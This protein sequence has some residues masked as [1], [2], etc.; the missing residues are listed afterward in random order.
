MRAP[1][2]TFSVKTC[3]L[4]V[5]GSL[6]LSFLP[7]L[8]SSSRCL[9]FLKHIIGCCLTARIKCM[10]PS[11]YLLRIRKGLG[12]C[13]EMGKGTASENVHLLSLPWT[14]GPG[15]IEIRCPF[16]ARQ[17]LSPVRTSFPLTQS[18]PGCRQFWRQGDSRSG[19][20][21]ASSSLPLPDLRFCLPEGSELQQQRALVAL[22]VCHTCARAEVTGTGRGGWGGS[23]GDLRRSYWQFR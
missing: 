20:S 4:L 17:S 11:A 18:F 21:L 6:L 3:C 7:H 12:P 16:S 10:V 8:D 13:S 15:K 14:S 2:S 22:G 9:V 1:Q 19:C 23:A 5:G